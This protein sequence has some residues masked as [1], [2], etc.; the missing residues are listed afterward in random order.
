MADDLARRRKRYSKLL[1]SGCCPRCGKAKNKREKYNYCDD[2]REY[3]RNYWGENTKRTQ[4]ER[5]AKYSQRKKKHLCP[6][7]GK[8]LPKNYIKKLCV[9]CLKKAKIL[10]T[11]YA[12]KK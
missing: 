3:Y 8:K 1:K 2:C 4:K 10:N 11:K 6:R 5:R 9:T 7:C 12:R